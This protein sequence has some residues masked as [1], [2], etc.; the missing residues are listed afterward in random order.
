MLIVKKL[1]P[2]CK[3]CLPCSHERIDKNVWKCKDGV[4]VEIFNTLNKIPEPK[5]EKPNER[6]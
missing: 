1:C 4:I 6:I 3:E 5:V 2:R